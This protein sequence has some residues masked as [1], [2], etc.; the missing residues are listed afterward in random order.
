MINATVLAPNGGTVNLRKAPNGAV[1]DKIKNGTFLQI[2][3][4]SDETWAKVSV[5]GKTG[6]MMKE[7]LELEAGGNDGEG[8]TLTLSRDLAEAL[9]A[10]L[11]SV[12]GV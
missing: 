3:N 11:A 6:Y 1:L 8:V 5:N 12:V 9:Y 4:D 7:F 10:A 2:T